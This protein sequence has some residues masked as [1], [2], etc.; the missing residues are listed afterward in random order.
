MTTKVK[1]NLKDTAGQKVDI[2]QGEYRRRFSRAEQPFTVDEAEAALLLKTGLFETAVEASPRA[3][4]A[5][6]E[7]SGTQPVQP[8]PS[9][10]E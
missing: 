3:V 9:E 1:L 8:Q 5:M 4:R 7:K 10:K 6:R 2:G